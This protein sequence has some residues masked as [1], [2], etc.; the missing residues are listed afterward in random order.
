MNIKD[1]PYTH[2]T[3]SNILHIADIH[4]RNYQRHKEYIQ[5]FKK[6]YSQIDKL[7]SN[8]IIVVAGD[9]VH[10][11]TDISPELIRVTSDFLNNLANRRTTIIITGNHDA[12]LNNPS[13]LDTITPIVDSINNKNLF[14]LKE[15]GI[16][17]LADIHLS[18]FNIYDN[19]E[20]YI[21]ADEFIADTKI[22]LFHGALDKSTTDVGYTVNNSNLTIS[23]F[24][25]YDMAL[26]GDIHKRQFY[27]DQKTILQV[28]SLIQQNFGESYDN[29]GCAVWDVKAR[30]C[31]FID[32]KNEYGF[33][34][35]DVNSGVLINNT[36]LPK[37]PRLRIRYN[38]TTQAELKSIIKDIKDICNPIDI[39]TIRSDKFNGI[40]GTT[41]EDSSNID[42]RDINYQ[43]T[44][45]A[46]YLKVNHNIDDTLLLSQIY[47]INSNLNSKLSTVDITRHINWKP[48]KFEF[49]NMFSYGKDNVI[50]FTKL[51]GTIGLFAPNHHGKSSI[52]DAISFCI[53]D[54][55]N[56]GKTAL[57]IMNN[58]KSWF[59]C[60][61]TFE[62]ESEIYCIEKLAKKQKN[63][64][65]KVDVNFY[66]NLDGKV[67]F[68]NGEQ[69]RDT[70]RN[71]KSLLGTYDDFI[72]TA[73]SLQ[74]NN[75]GFIDK[76]QSE[77][78]DLLAQFLD[79]S[80][81][82]ELYQIGNDDVKE[83]NILLKNFKNTDYPQKLVDL[84][85][86]NFKNINRNLA[87]TNNINSLKHT[88]D[89][90]DMEIADVS[91]KIIN[92]VNSYDID[93]LM[94]SKQSIEKSI[95]DLKLKLEKYNNYRTQNA[96]HIENYNTTLSK[97]DI[98]SINND[99]L[100]YTT[101]LN[102]LYKLSHNIELLESSVKSKQEN[103]LAI[104]QFDPNCDFCKST[105]FVKSSVLLQNQL[106]NDKIKY[107]NLLY[108][109]KDLDNIIQNTEYSNNEISNYNNIISELSKYKL[110]QSEIEVKYSK[111][112]SEITILN[113]K[114]DN[115]NN[116]IEDY[117]KNK[118]II[119]TNSNYQDIIT[120]KK[121]EKKL[122][123]SEYDILL[124]TQ[125]SIE[126]DIEVINSNIQ[127]IND[128]IDEAHELEIKLTAYEYYLDAV[129]RNGIPYGI[130]TDV[131]PK[132]ESEVNQIL[133]QVVDFNLAFGVDGKNILTHIVYNNDR[134]PL[135]LTSG[136]EKFIASLAIRVALIN[137]SNLPRPNFMCIDEGMGNLDS[138]NL[139]NISSFFDYLKSEFEFILIISHLDM[140][141]DTVDNLIDINK[142][143]GF[144]KVCI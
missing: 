19:P 87:V 16:Y 26:L 68:L 85:K 131:L 116:Q 115:I 67:E 86:Q 41:N 37:Y 27:N 72:L 81:F 118:F 104:G 103:L 60:K 106:D 136:M 25:G 12:N 107:K 88:I 49:S 142:S 119:E 71:I 117:N 138:T 48:I 110:Y 114:L 28:G 112:S 64:N 47:N 75:T 130:I 58:K 95:D 20:K 4:I 80:V 36:N 65:V 55:C 61:L 39:I 52:I 94:T 42:I 31:K 128:K 134:W 18:V 2:D 54:K 133:S 78:K 23:I 105:P 135:E 32:F 90:L 6:L 143:N 44:L 70:N 139:M 1:I 132:I 57:D 40:G 124:N 15:T 24:D 35:V 56:R 46:N 59:S 3:V 53:F 51:S 30:T 102:L 76:S 73:L 91:S 14:Y 9:I 63:G 8:S 101:T 129:K 43:N 100:Q 7:S 5:I 33:Y 93:Y 22:A 120:N 98:D 84:E 123:Q 96:L 127:N 108:Q 141:K 140:I 79:I 111:V 13:R 45:I 144:S 92:T 82:E 69:R 109:K 50:D 10:S 137:I 34:T 126:I 89:K 38:N 125:K 74:N 29:H 122:L 83:V 11:K 17:K 66:R 97:I 113:S 21:K 121:L 77:K 62:I 99:Y